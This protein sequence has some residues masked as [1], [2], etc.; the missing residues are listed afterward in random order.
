MADTGGGSAV[1]A[2]RS[3]LVEFQRGG[4]PE[5]LTT[6]VRTVRG[7]VDAAGF[8][9]LDGP[10][11]A[12]VWTL[13]A[14]AL[15][16]RARTEQAEPTDLDQAIDWTERAVG[17]W[18]ADH[19][20]LP[21]A[22]ANLATAL[23]DRYD[24]DRDPADLRRAL[25]L[26]DA[27]IAGLRATGVRLDVALHGQGLCYHARATAPGGSGVDDLDRAIERFR[28]A[29][30]SEDPDPED[31]AGYLNSLG[32]SLRAKGRAVTKP[33]LL[34]EAA[35]AF[36]AARELG[37]QGGESYV[38]ATVNL[39]G[40]LHERAEGD[41]DIGLL[42]EAVEL[43]RDV[44][45]AV[46]GQRHTRVTTNLATAL[47]DLYRYSRDRTL[48]DAAIHDLRRSAEDMPDPADRRAALTNLAAALHELFAN[49][50]RL[51][52]LDDAIAVQE[53]VL[54]PGCPRN[55]DR[56]LNL[57]ISL[58]DRFRRRR[59]SADLDRAIALFE[60]TARTATSW[61]VR[62]SAFNSHANAL[63]L[64]FDATRAR[65]D[66]DG[67][68]ELRERAVDTAAPGSLDEALYRGNLGVDLLTRFELDGDGRDLD[69]AVD[70][71]RRAVGKVPDTSVDWVLL[72]V[73]LADSLA[74]RTARRTADVAEDVSAAREAYR[75][76]VTAGLASRPEHALAAAM[77]WGDWEARRDCW[78]EAVEA[79]ES[80][81]TAMTRLVGRQ[82]LRADKESWLGDAQGLPAAAGLAHTR[83]GDPIR[84]VVAL[85]H[86]RAML[87]AEALHRRRGVEPGEVAEQFLAPPTFDLVAQAAARCP[88]VYFAAT[89]HGGLALVVRDG[90]ATP[91]PLDDLTA[92]DLRRRV[93]AHLAAYTAYRN[94]PETGRDGWSRSL[95][96]T[97]SWLW[98]VAVGPVLDSLAGCP[99]AVF[100]AG[101][102]L[103]L[104]P[105][106]AAWTEDSARPTGRRYALDELAIS[107]AP[108]ARALRAARE[109]AD[110][111]VDRRLLAVVDPAPV[112]APPLPFA[113][114]ES[115]GFTAGAGL[116]ATEL[117]GRRAT[118][119][120]FERHAANA[121]I[122]LLACHGQADLADPLH[123]GLLLAGRPVDLRQLM[124]MRLRIRLAVLSACETALPG[125]DLLDEV[126]G[127]PT[128]LLQAGVA[129][130]VA[131]QWAVPD[132]A[133]AMLMTEFARRWAGGGQAPTA[134]LRAAQQWLRDTTNGEKRQHWIDSLTTDPA[135]P[136]DVVEEYVAALNHAEP[137]DRDH[138]DPLTWAT[139][140][141]IGV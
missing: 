71:Q 117:P 76:A 29:L 21:G 61:V 11:R 51:T 111:V 113:R 24:R 18:P 89:D 104:L 100:V 60:E 54:G 78:T 128:G 110:T 35:D 13:G 55:P 33:G 112:A 116:T 115:R 53:E 23:S 98:T 68:I 43:Y 37:R 32:L 27:A 80:G 63:S 136:V 48:L 70:T 86:G 73:G 64:R 120:A 47:T 95:A 58:L 106:H 131:S 124:D 59:A 57:G 8:A 127:L 28:A 56:T 66:I 105:L 16:L 140:A 15:T 135:L 101:G 83:R 132:R 99:E 126:I 14:A 19:P 139:F 65:A 96:S 12:L 3:L 109:L 46:D 130:V 40:V 10:V 84:A 67:C 77:R 50:G 123:S 26:F 93:E 30:D 94:S 122:L 138:A 102:L 42:R 90:A 141:H 31:R 92:D 44:L 74:A 129:G 2:V 49:T 121:D 119:L 91:V 87:L 85:E 7:W 5:L 103:G 20:N 72:Q 4:E 133:T 108:N 88:L 9:D 82:Q 45:P 125:I 79:H 134:A 17:A 75:A 69:R 114:Y 62:A 39:A 81:L 36:R 118:P 38:A 97:G 52:A 107:Y 41:N 6:A 25:S 1:D 22:R 137:D 34:A